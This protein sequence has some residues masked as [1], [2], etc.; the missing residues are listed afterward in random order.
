MVIYAAIERPLLRYLDRRR[1]PRSDL[2]V[3][4]GP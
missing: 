4:N 1:R 3:A 2:I